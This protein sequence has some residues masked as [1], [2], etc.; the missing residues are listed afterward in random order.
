MC[1]LAI[2]LRQDPRFKRHIAI[3]DRFLAALRHCGQALPDARQGKNISYTMADFALAGFAPS[4]MQSP[5]LL[6]HQR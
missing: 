5:S 6:A 3:L 2:P 4:F 1:V